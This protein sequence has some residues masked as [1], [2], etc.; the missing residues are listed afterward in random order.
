MLK[1]NYHNE[2]VTAILNKE[3]KKDTRTSVEN[4][5]KFEKEEGGQ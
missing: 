5:R 3:K 2:I 4:Y 1:F